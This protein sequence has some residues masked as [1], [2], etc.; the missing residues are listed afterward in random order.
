MHDGLILPRS[1]AELAKTVLAKEYRKF[2]GVEPMLTVEM[3]DID[4]DL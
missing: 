2:V 3:A 1:K 4:T